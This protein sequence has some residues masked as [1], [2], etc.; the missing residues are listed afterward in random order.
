M[1][2]LNMCKWAREADLQLRVLGVFAGSWDLIHGTP[3][4]VHHHPEL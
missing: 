1:K 2:S 3:V 4:V